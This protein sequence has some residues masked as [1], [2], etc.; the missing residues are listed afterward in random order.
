M[1]LR[2]LY[3]DHPD[4]ATMTPDLA[5]EYAVNI[6]KNRWPEV[7]EIIRKDPEYACL[8][9]INVIKDR[10]PEAEETI[11]KNPVWAC[12]YATHAIKDRWPEAEETI[13][14]NPE[15]WDWY[16]KFLTKIETRNKTKQRAIELVRTSDKLPDE[17]VFDR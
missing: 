3:E 13:K 7:E 12:L 5:Y 1:R 6:I 16:Q 14:K 2:K 11:K 8:Y 9:A 17:D 10:W 15:W 4:P